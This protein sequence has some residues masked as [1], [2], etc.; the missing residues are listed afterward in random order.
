MFLTIITFV[1]I[2]SLLVFVH[3]LGHFWVARRFGV[4][5]EEFGFGFPPR[6]WGIYKDSEGKWRHAKG[7]E[8]VEQ[9]P[10]TVYSIN[11]I[12]LGGFV[13]IKGEDGEEKG[14]Q[15]SFASR[16]IW[17]RTAILLAGVTMNVILAFALI[18]FGYMSGLPQAL[19]GVNPK[20]IIMNEQ[21]Q[22][23]DI[24]P[25][26][27]AAAAGLKIGDVIAEIDGLAIASN[28][29]IS[30]YN[31]AN[32]GAQLNYTIKRGPETLNLELAPE[33]RPEADGRG[34]I[35]IGIVETGM[36]KYPVLTAISEGFKTTVYLVGAIVKAFYDLIK[37]AIMGD[38]VSA[39]IAGPIG[40]AALTGQVA[41]LGFIYILQFA[42]L[43]SI[44]LAII[45]AFPF[46]ALDGGR[47][48][49]LII[50]KIKGSPV[51]KEIEGMIH[52]IGFSLLMI[53]ILFVTIKDISRFGNVFK[54]LWERIVG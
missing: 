8:K 7:T 15:D 26:S 38:G 14:E 5:A 40:I 53:L 28:L 3:E 34:G 19:E 13:K 39:N 18:S 9:A 2:L 44:N 30:E 51:K 31:N 49:F 4:K 48:L 6:I 32:V 41:R 45:N 52:N 46:P 24:F 12:P 16:K 21:V 47:I 22:I 10:G 1:L 25:D 11:W 17:Q 37:G 35:G 43:L 33:A 29:E 20:G 42:A 23:I 27:P 54:G 36:V 50:E